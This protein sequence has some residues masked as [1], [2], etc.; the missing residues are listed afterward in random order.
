V[1]VRVRK[2]DGES[3][4]PSPIAASHECLISHRLS[5]PP[6]YTQFLAATVHQ[7]RLEKDELMF[8]AFQHFDADRSGFITQDELKKALAQGGFVS[9]VRAHST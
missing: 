5:H 2:L 8:K 9:Q 6:L 7:L 1:A 3:S 4:A